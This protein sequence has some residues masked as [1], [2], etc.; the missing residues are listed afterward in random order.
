MKGCW[1]PKSS[2][3]VSMRISWYLMSPA[4]LWTWLTLTQLWP[5]SFWWQSQLL[6]HHFRNLSGWALLP[7]TAMSAVSEPVDVLHNTVCIEFVTQQG[8]IWSLHKG[9]KGR[10]S[11]ALSKTSCRIIGNLIKRSSPEAFG[12]LPT[13][14]LRHWN[15]SECLHLY[16]SSYSFVCKGGTYNFLPENESNQRSEAYSCK[17]NSGALSKNVWDF[18][19]VPKANEHRRIC[20]HIL[21][22][23]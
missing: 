19:Q 7:H 23:S 5:R 15:T 17:S 3:N 11:S 6:Q 1:D 10:P 2:G 13:R 21:K 14:K 20:A 4:S 22:F 18:A 16:I 8:R 9:C 12:C